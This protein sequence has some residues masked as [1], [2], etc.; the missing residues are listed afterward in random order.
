MPGEPIEDGALSGAGLP[1]G[2]RYGSA[3]TRLG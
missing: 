3:R 2:Q 1:V